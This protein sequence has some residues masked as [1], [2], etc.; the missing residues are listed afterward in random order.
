M[1]PDRRHGDPIRAG[2]LRRDGRRIGNSFPNTRAKLRV[3]G[4]GERA[5]TLP[6][7]TARDA[8]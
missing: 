8:A 6:R 1:R 4:G 7:L 3:C 2:L 5:K